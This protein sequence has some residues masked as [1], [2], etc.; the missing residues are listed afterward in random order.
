[1]KKRMK[2]NS[3]TRNL[4]AAQQVLRRPSKRQPRQ[5]R[6]N[7]QVNAN[8]TPAQER[9]RITPEMADDAVH[10]LLHEIDRNGHRPMTH[11]CS[12]GEHVPAY[13]CDVEDSVS[14]S[15]TGELLMKNVFVA[16]DPTHCVVS[17]YRVPARTLE[18]ASAGRQPTTPVEELVPQ[19]PFAAIDYADPALLAKVFKALSDL[20]VRVPAKL[21]GEIKR[22]QEALNEAGQ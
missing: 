5:P 22:E 18:D 15:S 14:R 11:R 7:Q 2:S 6:S 12:T 13:D 1:M 16:F 21:R 10:A 9:R 4:R 8:G 3:P 20:G 19:K 17:Y